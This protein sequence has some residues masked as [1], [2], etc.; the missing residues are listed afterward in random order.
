MVTTEMNGAAGDAVESRT[1]AA[2]RRFLL[3]ALLVGV[4]GMGTELLLIGHVEGLLQL[5]P[6]LLLALGLAA[7]GWHAWRARAASVRVLQTTMV[8]FVISGLAG[9]ILHYRGNAEF[10]L[11]MY[12]T[13]GGVQLVR[14][15]LTGATPV[16]AP[17]SMTLLGL[18][19]LV[20]TYRHPRLRP[21][22]AAY[23]TEEATR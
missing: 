20:Q 8:L 11:E 10:E 19:G 23:S 17:G 5:T 14:E 15:T 2:I 1:L 9:V 7:A 18:V 6:V 22:G 12:P 4:A 3:G 16:L 21:P 13:L